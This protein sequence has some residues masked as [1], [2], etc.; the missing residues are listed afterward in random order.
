M[1]KA[2]FLLDKRYISWAPRIIRQLKKSATNPKIK[3]LVASKIFILLLLNLAVI[4]STTTFPFFKWH[5]GK[6]DPIA[7]AQAISTN[8]K[9][10]N[11]G[12]EKTHATKN[13]KNTN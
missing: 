4:K 11:K 5:K 10:P 12:L 13:R 9:S 3:E 1:L 2:L 8:S 6:N 7:T